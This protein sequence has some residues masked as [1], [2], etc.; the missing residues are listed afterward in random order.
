MFFPKLLRRNKVTKTVLSLISISDKGVQGRDREER[1]FF[2][3]S[4]KWTN[5]AGG[6][7][8]T[9]ERSVILPFR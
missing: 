6:R 2:I 7:T 1:S 9:G 5:M 3:E 8:V 4:W